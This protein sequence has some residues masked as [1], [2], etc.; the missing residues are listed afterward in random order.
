MFLASAHNQNL[1]K[2]P[3]NSASVSG[4]L[5][6]ELIF[7]KDDKD[8]KFLEQITIHEYAKINVRNVKRCKFSHR[9]ENCPEH[10]DVCLIYKS[11]N[12]EIHLPLTMFTTSFC[13]SI[14]THTESYTDSHTTTKS[15]KNIID[16]KISVLVEF[17][18][19]CLYVIKP[20][21][22]DKM[23]DPFKH[24]K[25]FDITKKYNETISID[26]S[27]MDSLNIMAVKTGNMKI[28][29][30]RRL[31]QV[32]LTLTQY[33]NVLEMLGKNDDRVIQNGKYENIINLPYVEIL[34]NDEIQCVDDPDYIDHQHYFSEMYRICDF[35]MSTGII[36]PKND[37]KV[38]YATGWIIAK[39]KADRISSI[40]NSWN[41]FYS[42][43][44]TN[45]YLIRKELIDY[46]A[47]VKNYKEFCVRKWLA[48][49][50]HV[51]NR[52]N[53]IKFTEIWN[54]YF[55]NVD[56]NKHIVDMDKDVFH[57]ICR[58]YFMMS[59]ANSTQERGYDLLKK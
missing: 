12:D 57:K 10:N 52:H 51:G 5:K 47:I 16:D 45:Q 31:E 22:N 50:V 40:D 4:T 37:D 35:S 49:N 15:Y 27:F 17:I 28:I 21:L 13:Q 25:P 1:F 54:K 58:G 48:L 6:D 46:D 23:S 9:S 7:V 42:G 34:K 41:I 36:K 39:G 53:I 20:C 59:N 55:R 29:N 38:F 43:E 44:I 3:V 24:M 8:Y 2:L 18:K 32:I 56:K 33:A 14:M 19:K 30:Q 11:V 26:F